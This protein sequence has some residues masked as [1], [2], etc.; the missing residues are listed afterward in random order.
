MCRPMRPQ[1]GES[2]AIR[3]LIGTFDNGGA[4]DEPWRG[5]DIEN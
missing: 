3:D 2:A 1:K 4:G 5:Q